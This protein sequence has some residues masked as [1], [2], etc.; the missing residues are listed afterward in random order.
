MRKNSGNNNESLGNRIRRVWDRRREKLEHDYAKVG[1]TLSV[2][3][4]VRD[5]ARE[6]LRGDDRKAVQRVVEKLHC[7]PLANLEVIDM[8]MSEIVDTFWDEYSNFDKRRGD[9]VDVVKYATED[10]R[11]GHSHKW[12]EKYSLPYTKVL[13]YVACRVCSKLA[14]IGAAE[15]SW[16]DV[17]HIK[18]GKR[19]H[20]SAASIEKR[21]ILYTSAR[22]TES[23]IRNSHMEKVTATGP[24]ALFGDDDMK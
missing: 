21:A 18:S 12:H 10:V 23:R 11:A 19:S 16:G 4:E 6:S 8:D 17:K 7:A 9:F 24:N 2:Y 5:D 15:R 14:G 13:G 1:W 3:P 20:I 22:V